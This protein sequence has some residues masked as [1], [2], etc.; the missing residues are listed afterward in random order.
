MTLLQAIGIPAAVVGALTV[1]YTALDWLGVR[2]V[3]SRELTP[4]IEEVA[5]TS[6]GVLLL[7]WQLLHERAKQGQLSPGDQVNYCRISRQLN[8]SGIGCA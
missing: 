1:T 4:I 8:L 5:A 6:S 2:P 7:Q 3:L